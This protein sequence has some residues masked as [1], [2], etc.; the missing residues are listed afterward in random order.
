MKRSAAFALAAAGSLL[1]VGALVAT[2][3]VEVPIDNQIKMWTLSTL[4]PNW[5]AMRDR[6]EFF[7]GFRTLL[8]ILALASVTASTLLTRPDEPSTRSNKKSGF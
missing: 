3:T 8:S 6:W 4:P 2:L 7:H 1:M 5:Q